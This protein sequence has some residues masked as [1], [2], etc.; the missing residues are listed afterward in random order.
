MCIKI[1]APL[2]AV[3]AIACLVSYTVAITPSHGASIAPFPHIS[4]EIL[5]IDYMNI[6]EIW[7]LWIKN[8][9]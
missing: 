6:T 3:I 7:Y 1:S 4:G 8:H 5:K 2:S 9:N